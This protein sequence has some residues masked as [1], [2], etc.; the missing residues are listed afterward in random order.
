M[1]GNTTNEWLLGR[2][3]GCTYLHHVACSTRALST[4]FWIVKCFNHNGDNNNFNQNNSNNDN[5]EDLPFYFSS[6]TSSASLVPSLLLSHKMFTTI[7]FYFT[8]IM[9]HYVPV[10]VSNDPICLYQVTQNSFEK[11]TPTYQAK[12]PNNNN[13]FA[14]L[15]FMEQFRIKFPLRQCYEEHTFFYLPNISLNVTSV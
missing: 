12:P 13:V 4:L 2:M 9:P 1:Y 11:L 15:A 8:S 6:S 10:N 5:N 7:I 14:S 3:D